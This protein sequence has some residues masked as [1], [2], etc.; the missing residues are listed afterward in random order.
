[1]FLFG[2]ISAPYLRAAD[3]ISTKHTDNEVQLLWVWAYLKRGGWMLFYSGEHGKTIKA[4]LDNVILLRTRRMWFPFPWSEMA[5]QHQQI[6]VFTNKWRVKEW[7]LELC[8]CLIYTDILVNS[9]HNAKSNAFFLLYRFSQEVWKTQSVNYT[10]YW[11]RETRCV[12]CIEGASA[13]LFND[14]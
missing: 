5:P 13:S 7:T 3:C 11:S 4:I 14:A 2:F 12:K 6:F 9:Q 1:M 8:Y 10:I